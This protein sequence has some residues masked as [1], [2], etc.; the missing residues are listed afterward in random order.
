MVHF[1]PA[2]G[3][4]MQKVMRGLGLI[5]LCGILGGCGS[6]SPGGGPVQ[7][8]LQSGWGSGAGAVFYNSTTGSL[9]L[10]VATSTG[11]APNGV[12]DTAG[13]TYTLAVGPVKNGTAYT[14]LYYAH[15]LSTG[16]VTT[17]VTYAPSGLA[18]GTSWYEYSNL[19]TGNPIDVSASATGTGTAISC[20]PLTTTNASDTI[21]AALSVPTA[22]NWTVGSGYYLEEPFILNGSQVTS[23]VALEDQK[24]STTGTYTPAI[25][26]ASSQPWT[27]LSIALKAG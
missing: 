23:A 22:I 12:T 16:K 3:H 13:N 15:N 1:K 21:L 6:A 14:S 8:T 25:T 11:A 10:I 20:A 17:T 7:L 4:L 18:S 19:A 27:C 2:K 24:V 5:L 26:A 9:F